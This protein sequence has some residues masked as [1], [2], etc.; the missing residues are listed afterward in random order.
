MKKVTISDSN[1]KTYNPY[2]FGN[3][4]QEWID[5]ETNIKILF[6]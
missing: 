6:T 5:K 4:T 3:A 1:N 2:I